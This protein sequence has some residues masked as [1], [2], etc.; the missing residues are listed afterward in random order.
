MKL[1][2]T[3]IPERYLPTLA[4]WH[5]LLRFWTEPSL[6]GKK[7]PPELAIVTNFYHG[8]R[9]EYN[10]ELLEILDGGGDAYTKIHKI[11]A[12]IAD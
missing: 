8:I 11:R 10:K 12:L 5:N 4:I 1:N 9:R 3:E 7:I 6:S 2:N